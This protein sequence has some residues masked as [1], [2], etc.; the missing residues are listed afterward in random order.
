MYAS[1]VSAI[2]AVRAFLLEMQR[3]HG[4][5]PAASLWTAGTSARWC[6]RRREVKIFL[7]ADAGGPGPA[8]GCRELEQRG[9]PKPYEQVLRG[10]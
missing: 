8:A 7:T 5:A 10:H 1:A 2:P 3:D 4:P 6:C 9:T